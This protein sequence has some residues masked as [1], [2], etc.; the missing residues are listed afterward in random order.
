MDQSVGEVAWTDQTQEGRPTGWRYLARE[1]VHRR[2][3]DRRRGPRGRE[4]L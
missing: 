1:P 3:R 4:R 2:R